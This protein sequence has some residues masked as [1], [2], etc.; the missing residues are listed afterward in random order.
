MPYVLNCF[1]IVT[2]LCCSLYF[3]NLYF[4]LKQWQKNLNLSIVTVET[5]GDDFDPSKP[6]NRNL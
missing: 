2:V 6:H 3:L 5:V 4:I 1:Y